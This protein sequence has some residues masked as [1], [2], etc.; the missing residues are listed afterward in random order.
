MTPATIFRNLATGIG[1][2]Q[3]QAF[4]AGKAE[5]SEIDTA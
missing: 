2:L 5:K 1:L 3:D 4:V